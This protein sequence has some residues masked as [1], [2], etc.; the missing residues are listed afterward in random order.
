M[1][2]KK[3]LYLL[4]LFAVL[5]FLAGCAKNSLMKLPE[6]Y[7]DFSKDKAL[8]IG[9][10]HYIDELGQR[11]VSS[12]LS[13]ASAKKLIYDAPLFRA[14]DGSFQ[15]QLLSSF[16][17]NISD[18]GEAVFT[19]E[20]R[21]NAMWH[22]GK[23][24][25]YND[26]KFTFDKLFLDENSPYKQYAPHVISC[27]QITDNS[28]KIVFS[29]DSKRFLELLCLP[30]LREDLW[31]AD[32]ETKRDAKNLKE[33]DKPILSKLP[34]GTGPYRVAKF[35]LMP[36]EPLLK[37]AA[38]KKEPREKIDY[39]YLI[40]QPFDKYYDGKF[41]NRKPVVFQSLFAS[42]DFIN[43]FRNK[44]F[45]AVFMPAALAEPLAS[46]LPAK[47]F[48]LAK[49][50]NPAVLSLVFNTSRP[51][52]KDA[53]IRQVLD[54][55]IDRAALQTKHLE[56][57]YPIVN[58]IF[59]KSS[60]N[61][62][63]SKMTPD[64][65]ALG[66]A[67]DAAGVTLS[68]NSKFRQKDGKDFELILLYNN[69]SPFRKDLA[70][71][72]AKDFKK[73][74]IKT[75]I[76]GKSWSELLD[77]EHIDSSSCILITLVI[78]EDKNMIRFLHSNDQV[79]T[80]LNLAGFTSPE[81]DRLLSALDSML[82]SPADIAKLQGQLTDILNQNP[83]IA[84]ISRSADFFAAMA[85]DLAILPANEAYQDAFLPS[86]IRLWNGISGNLKESESKTPK[87]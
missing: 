79:D 59:A 82:L 19:A 72:I 39:P 7:L 87:N 18:R 81:A 27:S 17:V 46:L 20:I 83:P 69:D 52:L 24:V 77:K 56:G 75:A 53:R 6:G 37:K 36:Q 11:D 26:F 33:A 71:F 13:E 22:D 76:H 78:P 40:L 48:K 2:T 73:L 84:F 31:K 1:K 61:P 5:L 47:E 67:L 51:E 8:I 14:L 21:D 15:P 9:S 68:S 74:S 23:L 50:K 10:M 35:H 28:F 80:S 58:G 49:F 32:E 34:V 57:Y 41:A 70:D 30:L 65:V 3:L 60:E 62:D 4:P 64:Y 44:T 55:A 66:K 42:E 54:K 63:L 12:N 86:A 16:N 85:G 25:T 43:E 38:K 29:R 45:D